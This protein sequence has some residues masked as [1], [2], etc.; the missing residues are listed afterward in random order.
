MILEKQ[1]EAIV[2]T[3]GDISESIGMSLDLESAQ[4][5]MQMLSK[6]LYSDPIGSTIRECASNALDSHRRAGVS[7]PIIVSL[8]QNE[9]NNTEFSVED[10]GIGLD[11]NDVE[12]I[13]S[14]YG[15]ST[16]RHSNNE[17]GMMGLGFKS[18]LAYSSSFYF[19]CRKDGIERKYMMYEGEDV[20]TIDFLY[21]KETEERNGVKIIVPVK[22]V[23]SRAFYDKIKSQLAY[24]ENVY[25]DINSRF[26]FIDNKFKIHR[27]D[28]FQYSE[29]AS[30]DKLHICLDN[31]YYPIDF[32]KLG[33][34]I[35]YS[36]VALRFSL[37]DG[38]YPTPNRESLK[39]TSEAIDTIKRKIEKVSDKLIDM[40]NSKSQQFEQFYE[41]FDFYTRSYKNLKIKEDLS[42]DISSLLPYGSK[43]L[44]NPKLKGYEYLNFKQLS[45]DANDIF[46]EYRVVYTV[47]KGKFKETKLTNHSSLLMYRNVIDASRQHYIYSNR[48]PEVKK[49]ILRDKHPNHNNE[50]YVIKKNTSFTLFDTN[51]SLFSSKLSYYDV[52]KLNNVPK[53]DWRKTIVEFQKLIEHIISNFVNLDTLVVPEKEIQR[54]KR[55]TNIIIRKQKLKGD[56]IVK[57]AEPLKIQSNNSKYCKFVPHTWTLDSIYKSGK[58][59]I[60][61]HDDDSN[62]INN[63]YEISKK[64]KNVKLITLSSKEL[65]VLENLNL[66][67]VISY[68]KFMKGDNK[69]FKRIVTS[70]LINNLINKYRSVFHNL[71]RLEQVSKELSDDCRKLNTYKNEY[72]TN[73]SDSLYDSL[74]EL[75]DAN[76]LYDPEMYSHY[77]QTLTK[78]E[79]VKNLNK[80][81]ELLNIGYSYQKDP[82]KN[83]IIADLFKYYK[84]KV[85]IEY[86]SNSNV[87]I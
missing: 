55:T 60:Y 4:I 30:D 39:Y 77:L 87:A 84:M 48:I 25:F 71:D 24:F 49:A 80:L 68:D 12:N 5:L 15:K 69:A 73:G 19:I 45:A 21:E 64:S 37:S 1:K 66:K 81:C 82:V 75:A 35:N 8:L 51:K 28:D 74:I 13:I 22:F 31:V 70:Y 63:L 43:S 26:G 29:L 67:N 85:N 2:V 57:V 17:L 14:K 44:E 50:G 7:D 78:L 83:E 86:Y 59:I 76:N 18:P 47:I 16:K 56:I 72:Y 42:I 62:K 10:F 23:D 41:V 3:D 65:K 6:N 38:L 46:K 79:K 33:I 58:F 34:K 40:Y 11:A 32:D 36:K 54:L 53:S 61:S 9:Q 52:L 27:D 20:N